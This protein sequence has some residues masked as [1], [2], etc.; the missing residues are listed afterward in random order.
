MVET[1]F[2]HRNS[3][4]K[5]ASPLCHDRFAVA[6]AARRDEGVVKESCVHMGHV[7]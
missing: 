5:I 1:A 3:S 2:F 6:E 7:T 4:M